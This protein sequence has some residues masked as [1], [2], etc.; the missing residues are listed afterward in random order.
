[1]KTQVLANGRLLLSDDGFIAIEQ[2]EGLDFCI[3]SAR[4]VTDLYMKSGNVITIS[5]ADGEVIHSRLKK[6]LGVSDE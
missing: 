4:D 3:K 5:R 6:D 2:I 1:M